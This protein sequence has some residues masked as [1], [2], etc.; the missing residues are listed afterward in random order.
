MQLHQSMKENEKKMS[1]FNYPSK[2]YRLNHK[3]T[4]QLTRCSHKCVQM[5][6]CVICNINGYLKIGSFR[7]ESKFKKRDSSHDIH[8]NVC[9]LLFFFRGSP[10]WG[11]IKSFEKSS[12]KT[13]Q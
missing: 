11:V 6:S 7:E 1:Q 13:L 3:E 2:H 10:K 9:T 8:T 12:I 4:K 5:G